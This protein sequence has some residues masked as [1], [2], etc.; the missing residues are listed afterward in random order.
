MLLTFDSREAATAAAIQAQVCA[1]LAS[2]W[3]GG[4]IP[5]TPDIKSAIG[6]INLTNAAASPDLFTIQG[7]TPTAVKGQV[8][9][10]LTPDA[11]LSCAVELIKVIPT[12]AAVE[13]PGFSLPKLIRHARDDA[14][15]RQQRRDAELKLD[16][17]FAFFQ[18]EELLDEDNKW[19][20]P[21]CQEHVRA[22]KTTD[23][24]RAP[25]VLMVHLKRFTS[26]A[27]ISTPVT[28]PDTLDMRPYVREAGSGPL[29]YRL[30]AVSEH[31][32]SLHGGHYTAHAFVWPEGA[33]AG[34]WIAFND[35]SASA[36]TPA[37]AHSAGAYILFYERIAA[38][39]G[40]PVVDEIS[41][42]EDSD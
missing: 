37:E 26:T 18:S 9:N 34:K 29:N 28:Y 23:V 8:V 1:K 27:K 39:G 41:D 33:R 31:G 35:Q 2:V 11:V 16:D 15:R 5:I 25:N 22:T 3:E 19:F 21:T 14:A 13:K 12:K 38:E 20:C 17:C 32:G 6:K 10:A 42:Q 36:A 4:D 24:W 7:L 30:Y 40:A